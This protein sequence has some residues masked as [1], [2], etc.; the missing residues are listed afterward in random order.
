M[1]KSTDARRD[2]ISKRL[3][4]EGEVKADELVKLFNVSDETIRKD[5]NYLDKMGVLRKVRGGAKTSSDYFQPPLRLRSQ[6]NTEAK[7]LIARKAIDFIDEG[8]LVY[9]DP[10]STSVQIAK[11]LRIKKNITV[12]TNSLAVASIIADSDNEVIMIGGNIQKQNMASIGYYA[13]DIIDS[14]RIDIAFMGTDGF[15][16]F[17]G[18]TTF[19]LDEAQVRRHVL[20]H[21]VKKILISDSSKFITSSIYLFGSFSDYD[22]LITDEDDPEHLKQVKDVGKVVCVKGV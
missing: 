17:E 2:E 22:I 4:E 7:K 21:S 5:L 18:P 13:G 19:S 20:K 14:V 11:F 9:L 15:L 16:G 12:I 6:K 3:I 1:S 10:G 8:Q